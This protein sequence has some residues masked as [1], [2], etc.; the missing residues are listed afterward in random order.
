MNSSAILNALIAKLGADATLLGY[1]PNGVYEDNAPEGQGMTK[2]V[3]VSHVI[4]NDVDVFGGR[5]YEDALFLV[6]ARATVKSGGNV[7]AA[8]AEIDAL[9]DP[10]PGASPS[11]AT[12]DVAGYGLMAIKREEFVRNTERDEIDPTIVWK[13]RGGRYRVQMVIT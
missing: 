12:L 10:R 7:A 6:E 9:L 11:R 2:F 1:M 5:A 3:I 8:A 4:T 13:R